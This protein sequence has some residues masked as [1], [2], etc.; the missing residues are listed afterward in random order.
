[1]L[2]MT[3]FACVPTTLTVANEQVSVTCTIKALNARFLEVNCRLPLPLQV[4]ETDFLKAIKQELKRGN[5]LLTLHVSNQNLFKGNIEPCHTIIKEYL[6]AIEC[7]KKDYS[8][9]GTIKINHFIQLP[10]IFS[11]SEQPPDETLKVQLLDLLKKAVVMV[12]QTR[13]Q[14]G[15]IMQEDVLARCDHLAQ[16]INLI[17]QASAQAIEEQKEKISRVL[18]EL[19]E[20]STDLVRQLLEQQ[21]N[22]LYDHLEKITIHEEIV[23]FKNHLQNLMAIITQDND[24]QGKR[25]DFTLQEMTREINTISAKSSDVAISTHAINIKLE[26][27]K[28]R[29]QAQNIL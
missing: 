9:H 25:I 28:I 15:A 22:Q 6:A 4:L 26:L 24:E 13:A 5:I 18:K 10:Q 3:G 8:I 1:M 20:A 21:H 16:E 14:E 17:E 27:E 29:E 19:E 23:R 11:T 12:Q 7:I 2:S